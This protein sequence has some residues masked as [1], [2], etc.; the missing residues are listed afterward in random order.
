[1]HIFVKSGSIYTEML[2]FVIISKL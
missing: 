1:V 2:R